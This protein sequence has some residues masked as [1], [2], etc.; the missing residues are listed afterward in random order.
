MDLAGKVAL[1]TGGTKGI[2]LAVA[3]D[4]IQN[5]ASRVIVSGRN[6]LDGLFD[7]VKCMGNLD[8]LVNGAG[9]LNES[10]KWTQMI[11]TNVRA[12]ITTTELGIDLMKNS[13]TPGGVVVNLSSIYAIKPVPQLPIFSA[14]KA[15][16]R[17]ATLGFSV[18]SPTR[19]HAAA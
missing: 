7:T 2:G 10:F 16:V 17:N 1:I 18:F 13:K 3:K 11:E 15:A 14:S 12:L 8:I 5:G 19:E 6:I 9:I 4:L